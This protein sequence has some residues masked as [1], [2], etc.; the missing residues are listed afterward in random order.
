[1]KELSQ[2]TK[3]GPGSR[4]DRLLQFNKRLANSQDSSRHLT[5]WNLQL[6]SELVKIPA[7]VLPYPDIL[8]GNGKKCV[9]WFLKIVHF[10]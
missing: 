5:E 6:D 9:Q 1:M 3:I 8:F 10:I 7:R 4:M 2:H